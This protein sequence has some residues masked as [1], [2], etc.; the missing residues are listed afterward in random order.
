MK[1]AVPEL[2]LEPACAALWLLRFRLNALIVPP[3][4][5][6]SL[7]YGLFYGC[8]VHMGGENNCVEDELEGN[9][10]HVH[11]LW[12][13]WGTLWT[14]P[15]LLLSYSS[16][17]GESCHLLK[18][19]Y[20]VP[21]CASWGELGGPFPGLLTN[22][23]CIFILPLTTLYGIYLFMCLSVQPTGSRGACPSLSLSPLYLVQGI[24]LK[25]LAQWNQTDMGL[26]S[27]VFH[28]LCAGPLIFFFMFVLLH[29]VHKQ[30]LKA[31]SL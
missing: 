1:T 7:W 27:P 14:L 4:I 16:T 15:S 13:T 9:Y 11:T 18:D 2:D 31:F 17:L 23:L 12:N 20:A 8:L 22:P 21:F 26:V 24:V 19:I 5:H 30:Y 6:S 28:L 10:N 3:V 25:L 29:W